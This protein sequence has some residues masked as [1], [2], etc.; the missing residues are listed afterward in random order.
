MGAHVTAFSTSPSKEE[1]AKSMGAQH[2]RIAWAHPPPHTL[3]SSLPCLP[4]SCP[5]SISPS[6]PQASR[7]TVPCVPT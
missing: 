4:P 3:T 7:S 5:L 2:G 1:E 6:N